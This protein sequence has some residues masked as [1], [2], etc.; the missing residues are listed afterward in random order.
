MKLSVNKHQE[1]DKIKNV[2]QM[3]D[4]KIS[5]IFA[6]STSL[7]EF[8]GYNHM[9]TYNIYEHSSLHD[10]LDAPQLYFQKDIQILWKEIRSRCRSCSKTWW[11]L[12]RCCRPPVNDINCN[13]RV[14]L[15]M[16]ALQL[17]FPLQ[18]VDCPL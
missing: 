6:L 15:D 12:V 5:S 7:T 1:Q 8:G 2:F 4:Y 18:V 3:S 10:M 16:N 17:C 11:T 13:S 9:K 14:S